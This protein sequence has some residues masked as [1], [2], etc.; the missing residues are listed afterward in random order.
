LNLAGLFFG[1][2]HGAH[3]CARIDWRNVS[4]KL[5]SEDKVRPAT[6]KF[7]PARTGNKKQAAE[8]LPSES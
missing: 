2:R 3:G 4:H 6:V 5:V 1:R 7:N 8:C